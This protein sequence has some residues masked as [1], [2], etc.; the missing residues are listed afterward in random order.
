MSHTVLLTLLHPD[1]VSDEHVARIGLRCGEV[2]H[3]PGS[4]VRIP[5]VA[6]VAAEALLSVDAADGGGVVEAHDMHR[7]PHCTEAIRA[8]HRRPELH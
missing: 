2:A 4:Q 3:R 1:G 7:R 6:G 5:E 8:S